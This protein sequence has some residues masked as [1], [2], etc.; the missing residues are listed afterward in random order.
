MTPFVRLALIALVLCCMAWPFVGLEQ[1]VGDH[2]VGVVWTPFIKHRPSMQMLFTNP[3]Q[4]GLDTLPFESLPSQRQAAF[5]AYCRVRFGL[6]SA[7]KCAVALAD[8]RI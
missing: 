8:H 2:E 5:L 7:Q 3:A 6:T 4:E 1:L